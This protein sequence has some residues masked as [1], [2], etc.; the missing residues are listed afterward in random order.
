M[1]GRHRRIGKTK[2]KKNGSGTNDKDEE[3]YK[4]N[5]AISWERETNEGRSPPSEHIE[6]DTP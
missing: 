2:R 1:E 6:R 5:E 4:A 3:E